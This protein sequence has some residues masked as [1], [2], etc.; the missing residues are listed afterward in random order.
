MSETHDGADVGSEDTTA[1]DLVTEDTA[2]DQD[3]DGDDATAEDDA[4]DGEE[5]D[6]LAK[7]RRSAQERINK[8]IEK[9]REAEREA[10]YWRSKAT[11]KDEDKPEAQAVDETDKEPDPAD[12]TFGETDP[13]FIRALARYE[14]RQAYREEAAKDR[15]QTHARTVE[16]TWADR[17]KEFKKERPDYEEKVY[18]G[19]K[20]DCSPAMA[21]AIKTSDLGAAVAYHLA[22]NP[23]EARRIAGLNPLAAIREIG[24][25]EARF[26]SKA[27]PQKQASDAP[28]PPPTLRGQ[29]GRFTVAPDTEDF[30]AF[31]RQYGAK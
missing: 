29:G 6:K 17:Q 25:L 18:R 28:P 30:A 13:G 15:Q 24:R 2:A 8:A 7:P 11:G 9:Q 27:A 23:E 20:W 16:E 4:A 26:D 14:G 1:A 10:E 19:S 21:D 12:Y 31:E 5:G 22:T 3:A